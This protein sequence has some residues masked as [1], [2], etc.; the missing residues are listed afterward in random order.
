MLQNLNHRYFSHNTNIKYVRSTI[1]CISFDPIYYVINLN[2]VLFFMIFS[3]F[4]SMF[5]ASL[6]Q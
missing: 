2:V 4:D 6:N 3:D 5:L 1:K